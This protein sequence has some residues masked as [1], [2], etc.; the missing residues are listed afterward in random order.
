MA[1]SQKE[2]DMLKNNNVR[3]WINYQAYSQSSWESNPTRPSWGRSARYWWKI[4]RYCNV[5]TPSISIFD[6]LGRRRAADSVPKH[7]GGGSFGAQE[8]N[9]TRISQRILFHWSPPNLKQELEVL[10]PYLAWFIWG[11]EIK[12]RTNSAAKREGRGCFGPQEWNGTQCSPENILALKS[13]PRP[14]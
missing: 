10:S 4:A 11:L 9:G 8:G 2:I 13:L 1:D 7:E 14:I 3:H 12:G 6:D 5:S